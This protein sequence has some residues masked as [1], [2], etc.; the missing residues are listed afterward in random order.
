MLLQKNLLVTTV[1]TCLFM[2]LILSSGCATS[3]Q[4]EQPATTNY[5]KQAVG[6]SDELSPMAPAAAKN[7]RKVGNQ[8]M[9]ELNGQTMIYNTAAGSWEPQHPVK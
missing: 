2:S 1:I 6:T 4:V 7:I 9:C 3:K 5:M 8:W